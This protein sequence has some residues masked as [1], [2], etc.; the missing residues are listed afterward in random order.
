M[1][2]V[3][4]NLY[5]AIESLDGGFHLANV[6][7]GLWLDY[8]MAHSVGAWLLPYASHCAEKPLVYLP[9]HKMVPGGALPRVPLFSERC[10]PLQELESIPWRP[11][12]VE[13]FEEKFVLSIVCQHTEE[14]T[15][16]HIAR[17]QS[18]AVCMNVIDEVL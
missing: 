6:A 9:Q 4:I 12:M 10:R 15:V 11:V 3:I 18:V 7:N 16:A 14:V 1:V 17:S 13:H 8:E 2:F 5:G